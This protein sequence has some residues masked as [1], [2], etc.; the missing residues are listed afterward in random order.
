M[1][2][3]KAFR[4][5]ALLCSAR[6]S[7]SRSPKECS[8]VDRTA[9]CCLGGEPVVKMH[10]S[11]ANGSHCES[12]VCRPHSPPPP[13]R[14]PL[15]DKGRAASGDWPIVAASSGQRK[16]PWRHASPP[17]P[18]LGLC[19]KGGGVPPPPPQSSAFNSTRRH[20]RNPNTTHPRFQPPVTAPATDFTARPNRFVTALSLPPDRPPLQANPCPPPQC[21]ACNGHELCR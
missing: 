3:S 20:V 19:L 2:Q 17:P 16:Q 1:M 13:P 15:V 5:G 14:V 4:F 7:R 11:A 10:K 6:G 12:C 8:D 21:R 18:P 9:K